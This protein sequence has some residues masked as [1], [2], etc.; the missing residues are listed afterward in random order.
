MREDLIKYTTAL[1]EGKTLL[2]P[3][4]TIWGLGCDAT[5]TEAIK[6]VFDLKNRPAE[7]SLLILVSDINMLGRYFREI[8]DVVF[9]LEENSDKPI[10]Y[11]LNDPIGISPIALHSDGSLGVRIPKNEF[12]QRMI[13]Q[14]GKA[15]ISTSANLHQRPFPLKFSDIDRS[16]VEKAD[17]V[18]DQKYAG[19][20][21][22]LPSSIIK[23]KPNGEFTIIR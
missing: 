9:D 20:V 21:S 17:C 8:P 7:K 16:I 14:F 23:I 6:R 15:I 3:T 12:C 2:Y 18:V 5:N 10:T 19:S 22:N 11:I 4:D 13:K 1:R